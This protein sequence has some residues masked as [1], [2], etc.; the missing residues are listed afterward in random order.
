MPERTTDDDRLNEILGE[1]D[2]NE[3][4]GLRAGMLPARYQDD[5]LSGPDV[6]RLMDLH[7]EEPIA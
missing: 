5:D 2:D 3:L 4:A 7:G 6:A 1:L